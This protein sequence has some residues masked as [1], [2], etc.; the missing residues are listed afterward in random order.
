MDILSLGLIMRLKPLTKIG[1]NC[2]CK[3][4]I[5]GDEIIIQMKKKAT[6]PIF[7]SSDVFG[8][9]YSVPWFG[10]KTLRYEWTS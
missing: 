3:G 9:S 6:T 8:K 5:V 2:G 10:D 7:K 1:V 4:K